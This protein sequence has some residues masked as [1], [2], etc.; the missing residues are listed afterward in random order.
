MLRVNADLCHACMAIDQRSTDG[1]FN[2]DAF[3]FT[4]AIE[5]HNLTLSICAFV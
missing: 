4:C 2:L 3:F 5:H 1:K